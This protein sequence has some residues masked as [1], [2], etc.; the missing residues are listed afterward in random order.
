MRVNNGK[1]IRD[2]GTARKLFRQA[3]VERLTSDG[4]EVYSEGEGKTLQVPEDYW[5]DPIIENKIEETV[6]WILENNITPEKCKGLEECDNTIYSSSAFVARRLIHKVFGDILKRREAGQLE[7]RGEGRLV[8]KAD[9][10][11]LPDPQKDYSERKRLWSVRQ[12]D[13]FFEVK[14][15]G[16]DDEMLA[17]EVA[18]TL[19]AQWLRRDRHLQQFRREVLQGR[20]FPDTVQGHEA[21]RRFI[22]SP[23]PQVLGVKDYEALGL[24]PLDIQDR[25]KPGKNLGTS[26]GKRIAYRRRD[27]A[28]RNMLGFTFRIHMPDGSTRLRRVERD[29]QSYTYV[30][31]ENGDTAMPLTPNVRGNKGYYIG[32]YAAPW[33]SQPSTKEERY[34]E[35]YGESVVSQALRVMGDQITS[36]PVD[37]WQLLTF[38]LTDALPNTIPIRTLVSSYDYR[39]YDEDHDFVAGFSGYGGITL[40]VQPWVQPESLAR[41]WREIRGNTKHLPKKDALEL[42]TFALENTDPDENFSWQ[43]LADQWEK[44]GGEKLTRDTFRKAVLGTREALFPHFRALTPDEI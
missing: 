34:V 13:P 12:G 9:D 18:G 14:E 4:D 2:E 3:V 24:C 37:I 42:F 38:L 35:C 20:L 17:G 7:Q 40:H 5:H 23:V 15:I 10:A 33:F 44:E 28:G 16:S 6:A 32:P 22:T 39:L 8:I 31:L 25:Y 36:L 19:L 27:E 1:F 41:H 11:S 26:L 30:G 43:A 29:A 21:A